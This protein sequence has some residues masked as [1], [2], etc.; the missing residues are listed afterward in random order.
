MALAV[1]LSGVYKQKILGVRG[2]GKEREWFGEACIVINQQLEC[3]RSWTS[4]Q[5]ETNSA[6]RVYC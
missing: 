6:Q 1:Q 3:E 5:P 4:K 2:G